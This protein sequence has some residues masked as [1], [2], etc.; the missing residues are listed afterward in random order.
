MLPEQLETDRL[1]LQRLRYEDADEI[2]YT[3]ASKPEATRFVSW[4]THK[5][6]EDTRA[7]LHYAVSAW[8][9]NIDFSYAI[10]LKDDG[11]LIGSIGALNDAG[12]VQFGYVLSP[13]QWGK[14]Y[15]TE[16]CKA[17]LTELKKLHGIYRIWTLV[18]TDNTA[19][20]R[21]LMKC[22]LVEECIHKRWTRFVN[23]GDQPRDCVFFIL[24]Q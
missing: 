11:R 22:G 12:K 9:R 1:R 3:Y 21:V 13:Q 14:G 17:M 2:F 20:I 10:R 5:S 4:A 7:Y 19:S 8:K 15:A 6:I 24:P 23:Q 18:D 16:A